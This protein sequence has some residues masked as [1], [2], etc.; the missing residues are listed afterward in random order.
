MA[1]ASQLQLTLGQPRTLAYSEASRK[2]V[3]LLEVDETL[4]QELLQTGQVWLW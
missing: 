2:D 4:L 1:S 3:K